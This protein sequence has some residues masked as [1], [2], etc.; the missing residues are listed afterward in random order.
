MVKLREKDVMAAETMKE[1]GQSVRSLARLFQVDE[2][3]VRYRLRRRQ[4]GADDGRRCQAE[5]C[6]PY[7][8]EIEAWMAD[9]VEAA[10]R[11]ARPEPVVGL[12]ERLVSEHGYGGSYKAVLRYVRRRQGRPRI[13][14]RRRVEVRF[15]TQ[16]QVDWL[17]VKVHVASLG[18]LVTLWAFVMVL[19]ASRMWAVVWS[20]G[21]CLESWL[22]CHNE[23]FLRLGGV[24]VSVRP[25]NEKTAIAHGAGPWGRVNAGYQS[26]AD[27]LGFVVNATLPRHPRGKGKVERRCR[28]V[29][30]TRVREGEWFTDLESLQ[31]ATDER[32]VQRARQLVCPRTGT[33]ILEAWHQ[34]QLALAPVPETL[35]HPFDVEV[36]RTVGDDC[37]VAFEGRQYSVG[38]EHAGRMMRVRGC[39]D[40]VEVLGGLKVVKRYPRGTASRLL[41]D[42]ADDDGESTDEVIAPMPLGELG[43]R[44]VL[45]RSWEAPRR[46]IE[47]YAAQV[48]GAS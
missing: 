21:K 31:R 15:G 26:Y 19:S 17:E 24:P 43:R 32:V 38:F 8:A 3:T 7:A 5:V 39:G 29:R 12:Y 10:S 6:E 30:F 11:G 9:Q 47:H 2:S 1:H 41:V 46:A 36:T 33:S 14:A 48:G 37:L 25:D 35:P 34:E 16:A 22:R 18:G 28:D 23:A 40:T 44:I 20:R 4:E 42:Q 27:Q 13:R 45:E